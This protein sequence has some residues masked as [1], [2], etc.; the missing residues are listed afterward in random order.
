MT[1]YSAIAPGTDLS[2]YARVLVRVHDAVLGGGR[3]PVRPRGV[4]A[5]S[6][7]RVLG[8]GLDPSRTNAREP[9][10]PDEV[11]RRRRCSPLLPVI[12]ELRQVLGGV[13]DASAFLMVV[14]DADGVIL[15]REGSARIRL[16]AD[17]LGFTEGARWTEGTVG[18]N[19]IGTALAEAAPVQLFSAEHFEQAQHPWY[20]TAAPIHHPVSGDLL[21]I[22]DVSGPAL[23]LHPVI[24]ALVE[25]A[26]KL[27]ES[28]LWRHH[29]LR[30]ERV[31]QSARGVLATVSGPLLLVDDH[32]WVAHQAGIAARDR[33]AVP[34][35]G[36]LLAVPGLGLCAPERV[37][38]GWLVRPRGSGDDIVAELDLTGPPVLRLQSHTDL[39]VTP[40]SRRHAGVLGLLQQAGRPGLSAAQ[41]STALFGDEQHCVTV[42]A[43]MSRLRKVIGGL[44]TTTPYRLAAGVTLRV[45]R[46]DD[47]ERTVHRTDAHL[48]LDA[49]SATARAEPLPDDGDLLG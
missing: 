2:Q 36:T 7:S 48:P 20:C 47:E 42:R 17:A 35:G 44:V 1:G 21:G 41:L 6:W 18:T 19:A 34:R 40:L 46:P 45:V 12:G 9:L 43:E 5:R 25:T 13:A 8:L 22:V 29:E 14:T 39:W 31:R 49:G 4:V 30:L 23:T 26:V 37:G 28:Q 38:E 27:A 24:G 11:E 10:L 32:G 3:P 33:V 16:R 15:W